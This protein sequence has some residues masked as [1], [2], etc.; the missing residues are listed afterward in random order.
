MYGYELWLK[1]KEYDAMQSNALQSNEI[2]CSAVQN[3]WYNTIQCK[4]M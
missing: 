1:I 3:Q 2:Q 4:A